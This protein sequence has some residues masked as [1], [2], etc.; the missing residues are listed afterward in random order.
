MDDD[1]LFFSEEITKSKQIYSLKMPELSFSL[2]SS[3]SD[4]D[5]VRSQYEAC[6]VD[7]SYFDSRYQC[8]FWSTA[9]S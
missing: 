7:D 6:V 4:F 5:R 9:A 8:C 3:V 2:I 1:C